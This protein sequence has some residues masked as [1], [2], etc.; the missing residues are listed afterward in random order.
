MAPLSLYSALLFTRAH[1]VQFWMH[2]VCIRSLK[3]YEDTW[4]WYSCVC[5][6]VE[7]RKEPGLSPGINAGLSVVLYVTY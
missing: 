5:P 4:P 2:T 1:R 3:L 7:L 6:F